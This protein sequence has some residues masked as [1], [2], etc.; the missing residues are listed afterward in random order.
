MSNSVAAV[1]SMHG[2][3]GP[4]TWPVPSCTT[5][6]A[7]PLLIRSTSSLSGRLSRVLRDRASGLRKRKSGPGWKS[8]CKS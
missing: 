1:C 4:Q 8:S 7:C 3:A 2:S 5:Q 6:R